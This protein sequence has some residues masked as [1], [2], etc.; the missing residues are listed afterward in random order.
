MTRLSQAVGDLLRQFYLC[1][2][3]AAHFEVAADLSL[4]A[5][6]FRLNE[7]LICYGHLANAAP[8]GSADASLPQACHRIADGGNTIA[9]SFDP[10]EVI[11]SL[12]LERYMTESESNSK[13]LLRRFYYLLRPFLSV[14]VRKH[15]QRLRLRGWHRIPFPHWPVDRTVDRLY[16]WLLSLAMQA[17]GISETPFVW[18]W[19]EGYSSCATVTHD[20]E[21]SAGRDFCAQLMD[22]NDSYGVK[23]SFQVV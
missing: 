20:V 15:V 11:T 6:F 3:P 19:P 7:D 2:R 22:I 8:A 18:F 5:G 21:T 12:R 13:D 4:L 16:E 1:P 14:R 23:T 17:E 9:L 10:A